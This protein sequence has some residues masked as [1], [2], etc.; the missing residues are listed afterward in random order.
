MSVIAPGSYVFSGRV[1]PERACL[2]VGSFELPID[3]TTGITSIMVSI[4]FSMISVVVSVRDSPADLLTLRHSMTDAAS[5]FVDAK[6][7]LMGAGFTVELETC[8]L[9]DRS[10][11]VFGAG[12]DGL[13]FP[14]PFAREWEDTLIQ[15]AIGNHFVRLALGD[16]RRAIRE[17]LSTAFYCRRASEA[18]METFS[19]ESEPKR[20]RQMQTA[21]GLT[22]ADLRRLGAAAGAI[23]HARMPSKDELAASRGFVTRPRDR[24][25]TMVL[26]RAI[27]ARYVLWIRNG[28]VPLVADDLEPLRGLAIDGTAEGDADSLPTGS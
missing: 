4:T 15:L 13:G 21:L 12:W 10:V 6:G 11:L 24:Q 26:T 19:G 20:W 2:M 9:P 17:P 7:F 8:I 25:R 27:F 14:E 3:D 1:I 28:Q 5:A 18:L 22:E 23:R 16:Y